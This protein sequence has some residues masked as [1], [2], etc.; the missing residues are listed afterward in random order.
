MFWASKFPFPRYG[1]ASS[2]SMPPSFL[3]WSTTQAGGGAAVGRNAGDVLRP[4]AIGE[5]A[6]AIGFLDAA[7]ERALAADARPVG[8]GEARAGE[9]AGREGP[10]V[11]GGQGV[12]RGRRHR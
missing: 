3:K 11:G 2:Q 6:A 10:R 8:V 12:R 7:G 4:Q 1:A 5:G 9:G